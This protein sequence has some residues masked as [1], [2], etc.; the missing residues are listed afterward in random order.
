MRYDVNC[1]KS[2]IIDQPNIS[3]ILRC[4]HIARPKRRYIDRAMTGRFLFLQDT[5]QQSGDETTFRNA[6][7]N[8][9]QRDVRP[10]IAGRASALQK[11]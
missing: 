3:E 5:S 4:H 6:R 9:T 7:Q 2:L 8:V 11:L 10:E 1:S